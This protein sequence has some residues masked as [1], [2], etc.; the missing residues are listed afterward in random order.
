MLQPVI[1]IEI[2]SFVFLAHSVIYFYFLPAYPAVNFQLPFA[3][4][5][6]ECKRAETNHLPL[7][8]VLSMIIFYCFM[9]NLYVIPKARKKQY[10]CNCFKSV[11]WRSASIC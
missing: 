1:S 11:R 8:G 9:L 5:S 6:N 3:K 7:I 10:C 4:T 2:A